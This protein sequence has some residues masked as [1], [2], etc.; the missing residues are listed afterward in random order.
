MNL[1]DQLKLMSADAIDRLKAV[2]GPIDTQI[3]III[4]HPGTAEDSFMVG[5]HDLGE[6]AAIVT[7]LETGD[8]AESDV[9]STYVGPNEVVKGSPVQ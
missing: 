6:L 1:L 8:R 2:A 9:T 5:E 4:G 7:R 3:T